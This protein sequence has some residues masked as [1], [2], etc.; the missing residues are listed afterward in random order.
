MDSILPLD[1]FKLFEIDL[2]QGPDKPQIHKLLDLPD[3]SIE[4]WQEFNSDLIIKAKHGLETNWFLFKENKLYNINFN[5]SVDFLYT[6]DA[7]RTVLIIPIKPSQYSFKII[8]TAEIQLN[9]YSSNEL[10]SKKIALIN[11]RIP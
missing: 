8:P 9:P 4:Y 10:I 6:L 3:Y 1:N 5:E 11:Q 7:E 2:S